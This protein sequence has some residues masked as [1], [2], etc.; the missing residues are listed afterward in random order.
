VASY[1]GGPKLNHQW[2]LV[3]RPHGRVKESDF[4]WKEASVPDIAEGQILVRILYLSLDP[5]NRIWMEPIDSYLP[6]LPLG[7]IMRGITLGVIE[8]SRNSG[9]A[10]G[11][12]V[13]GLGGW[14]EYYVG[15]VSGWT[16]LPRIPGLPLTAFLGA[17]GHI[18]FTA[19]FGLLDIGRPRPGE[20]L[21]IS[22]AAGAVGSVAGQIGKIAGCRVVGIAGSDDKCQWITGD[23]GFDVAINYKKENVQDA[24]KRACP[25]GIDIDFENVGGDILDAVL[26]RIN[27]GARVVVSGLISRYNAAGPV[28]G[29]SN[30]GQIL[31]KRARVQGFIVR[32]F[33]SRYPEAATQIV[34]W[35]QEGKLKY[36]IDMADGL[37]NA[38]TA[39]N[40]LFDGANTGRL[41][42]RVSEEPV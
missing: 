19:Y 14:Q 40:K 6:M 35:L 37:C 13:L 10:S 8:V 11:D 12:S 30:F 32:D 4:E 28:A 42:V 39:L 21:V 38:P 26:E 16:K 3:S 7:A 18:G 20:T 25:D 41:L 1:A 15:D 36:R 9:Y 5:T 24:L 29:P 33:S 2:R 17:V 31:V 34:Q 23:L 27:I 22:A